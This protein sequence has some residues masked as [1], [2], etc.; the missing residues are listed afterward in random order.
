M[1]LTEKDINLL[2]LIRDGKHLGNDTVMATFKLKQ[3]GLMYYHSL[4]FEL[5]DAG[6]KILQKREER[7]DE[8]KKR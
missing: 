5:T 3:E 6:R 2:E 4:K 1:E 8:E 7:K